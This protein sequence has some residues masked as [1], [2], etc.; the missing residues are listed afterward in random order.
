MPLIEAQRQIGE[1][2]SFIKVE[3]RGRSQV[4]VGG[5][6]PGKAGVQ[7]LESESILCDWYGEHIWLSLTGPKLKVGVKIGKLAVIDHLLTVLV[8]L[9]QKLWFGFLDFLCCSEFFCH[10][11]SGHCLFVYC[12]S[13]HIL[14]N[15]LG[16]WYSFHPGLLPPL[17]WLDYKLRAS[18]GPSF[19][20]L[21]PV[22][23]H[24]IKSCI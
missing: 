6:W 9:L 14:R 23:R 22:P 18:Y 13:D 2:E 7:L 8:Q 3:K 24:S 17:S 10:I 5:C 20:T 1:R 19:T 12:L 4:Y 15:T 11:Q 16:L 21:L